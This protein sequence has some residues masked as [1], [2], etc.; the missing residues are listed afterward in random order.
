MNEM[1]GEKVKNMR[2]RGITLIALVITIIVL[3]ILAGVSIAMLTGDNGILTKATE[4]KDQT[5]IGDEKEKVELS[6]VG[7]LAKDNGGEIKRE[8]LNDELTSYIGTE[9]TDYTLSETA[10][11]VVKYLD[12][13]RS[14]VIDENGNVINI[15]DRTGI[16]VGDYVNYTYDLADNYI[17]SPEITGSDSNSS[18]GISQ[19]KN[20]KWRIFDIHLDGTVDLISEN[21][22][23]DMLHFFGVLGYNN[24]VFIMNDICAKQYSNKNLG[25]ISR[26]INMQDIDNQLNEEGYIYKENNIGSVKTYSEGYNE[27]PILYSQEIGSGI[28]SKSTIIN[29]IKPSDN[30]YKE[31]TNQTYDT[32]NTWL[33][34]TDNAYNM[35]RTSD[36]FNSIME[37]TLLFAYKLSNYW[38]ASRYVEANENK[39]DFGLKAAGYAGIENK[40]MCDSERA[41]GTNGYGYSLRPIVSLGSDI[42]IIPVENAD[43]STEQNMH[44]IS[45]K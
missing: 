1:K 39:A 7:A 24:G 6:A 35:N 3:L 27:Y 44:Q 43:G 5:E 8:Y 33:T 37:N 40:K 18:T 17:L 19:T 30:G 11:F 16:E 14:Y 36:Y 32:A 42:Q 20:L 41:S 13:G 38:V 22:T 23:T 2:N 34:V 10:P 4:A 12:S 31:P 25:I 29:G 9:G 26:N 45:K 21:R 28:N 15:P